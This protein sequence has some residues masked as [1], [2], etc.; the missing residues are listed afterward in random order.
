MPWLTMTRA[1]VGRWN[2]Q[3]PKIGYFHGSQ[4]GAQ[5]SGSVPALGM[6]KKILRARRPAPVDTRNRHGYG[7]LVYQG[8]GSVTFSSC[9]LHSADEMAEAERR[10]RD[11]RLPAGCTGNPVPQNCQMDDRNYLQGFENRGN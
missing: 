11:D 1:A 6:R 5:C 3:K 4:Q 2:F 8:K 7:A 9:N 10:L